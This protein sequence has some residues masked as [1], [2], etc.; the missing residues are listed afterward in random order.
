MQGGSTAVSGTGTA[1]PDMVLDHI[2]IVVPSIEAAVEHWARVFGYHARTAVVVNS[3]Q[4]VRVVFLARPGSLE[5]K[6]IEPTDEA[7][8]IHG[9]ARRGGGLHHLCFR[10]GSLEPELARLR[11]LGL[12]VITEPEPGEAFNDNPIAFV[13]AGDGLNVELVDTTD[14]AGLLVD[15]DG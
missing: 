2:G 9:F 14:R 8:P 11:A 7:S 13:Y 10:V 4:R 12:R 15:R 3:R 5:V 6:L 1:D